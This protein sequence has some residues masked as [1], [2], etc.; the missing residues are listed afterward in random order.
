MRNP[1]FWITVGFLGQALFTAR[2]LVQWLA[3]E[4]KR[5]SVVPIAFWWLSLAGGMTLLSYAI[6]RRDP[7]I[8]TGQAMGIFVYVRNL[9][10][11]E[12]RVSW[13]AC[14][15]ARPSFAARPVHKGCTPGQNPAATA[16]TTA[17]CY[18]PIPVRQETP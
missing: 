8:V 5:T 15:C 9:M 16:A 7:V 10:L 12:G 2:F 14:D 11:T 4:Q 3:S 6:S 1:P 17:Q 18:A 13:R